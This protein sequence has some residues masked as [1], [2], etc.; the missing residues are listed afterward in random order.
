MLTQTHN[1]SFDPLLQNLV[2]PANVKIVKKL[3]FS[4]CVIILFRSS[5]YLTLFL[6]LIEVKFLPEHAR[7]LHCYRLQGYPELLLHVIH[8]FYLWGNWLRLW[9]LF[10][11]GRG[12]VRI[13]FVNY[14][15]LKPYLD[16][17][18]G[19]LQVRSWRIFSLIN[20]LELASQIYL[21]TARTK[22]R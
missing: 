18:V 17:Y 11:D 2:L 8:T 1:R 10:Y 20:L 6:F 22:G 19:F 15:V 14:L 7:V 9:R 3:L 4:L 16:L 21:L 13:L 5:E 12:V